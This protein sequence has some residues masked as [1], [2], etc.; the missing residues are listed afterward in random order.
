[1]SGNSADAEDLVQDTCVLACEHVASLRAAD[2]PDRWLLRVLY[3]R[4]IDG[5]RREA[6]SPVVAEQTA[7]ATAGFAVVERSWA[8]HADLAEQADGE[9]AFGRA[10]AKL[11]DTQRVLLSLRAEGFGLLEI[12]EITGISRDV[13]RARLH[14]AR[15]AL[16]RHLDEEG[17]EDSPLSRLGVG[18]ESMLLSRPETDDALPTP[19]SSALGS[20]AA[21]LQRR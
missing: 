15:L 11:K 13:L 3:N 12:E 17:D 2:S 20:S 18:R 9:R 10:C 6:R 16:A 7:M 21:L 14:R 1:L 4:Y 19:W 5:T 8:D